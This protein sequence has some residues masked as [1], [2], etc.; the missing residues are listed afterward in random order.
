MTNHNLRYY[1]L[2]SL[3]GL[4]ALGWFLD[5]VPEEVTVGVFAALGVIIGADW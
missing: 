5:K 4:I 1:A 3:T 2:G